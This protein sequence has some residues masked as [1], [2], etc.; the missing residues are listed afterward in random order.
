MKRI[1]II[2]LSIAVA[3]VA[4]FGIYYVMSPVNT[5]R[6]E[7]IT[8]ENSINTNG[9]IIRDEW[10]MYT[11]SAGTVYHSAAEGE[12]VAKDSVIGELFYGDVSEDSIKELAVVDNKIKNARAD[13]EIDA[14]TQLDGTGV[15]NNIYE[16]ENMIIAAAE[17]ND[18]LSVSKYKND[19]NSLRQNGALP[20]SN[21]VGELEAQREQIIAGIGVAKEDITANI[22]GVFTTYEDGYES[23]LTPSDIENYDTAYFES[24]SQ[25]PQVRKIDDKAEAGGAICKIV[26]NHVWYVMMDVSADIISERGEGDSVKMRFNNMAGTVVDGTIYHISEEENGRNVVT[27]KCSTYVEN[28]FSYRLAD[29]DLIFESYNGYKVPV[30]AIHTD[31]DGKQKVIGVSNGRQYDCYCNLLFTN[32]DSG[33]TIVQ[34]TD[35]AANKLSQMERIVVG[36]R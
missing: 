8:Q 33:Y 16:R 12:R 19:I 24:L 34:S 27:V 3:A 22:S 9:F 35:D 23:M 2:A 15:E 14:L 10:V 6:L 30:H 4:G 21:A 20:D 1:F 11:R 7:Y 36:E 29:V 5:Q 32:T 13:T 26:N 18:I 28:A 31:E 25:S 17:D